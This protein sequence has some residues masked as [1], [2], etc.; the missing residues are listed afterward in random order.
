MT[1]PTNLDPKPGIYKGH[2][3]E[4]SEQYGESKNGNPELLI[5]MMLTD[6]GNRV[7]TTP[8]YFSPESAP[9]SIERLRALGWET[10]DLQNLKG[11]GK[12]EVGIEI[13]YDLYEGSWKMKVQIQS[14]A[15]KFTTSKPTEK[16]AWA[17]KVGAITGLDAGSG[18]GSGTPPK[19]P[20]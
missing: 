9:Y 20:F 2:A 16:A 19:A 7:V 4:G 8:L 18:A 13:K 17:A 15:G 3:V 5:D 12:N 14:G 10:N 1:M 11:I 6:L